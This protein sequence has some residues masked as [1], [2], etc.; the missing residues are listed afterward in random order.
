MAAAAMLASGLAAQV[1]EDLADAD[2]ADAP[3]TPA[4]QAVWR[5]SLVDQEEHA[6]TAAVETGP[7]GEQVVAVG[8]AGDGDRGRLAVRML[9]ATTGE[10]V[11]SVELPRHGEGFAAALD[12]AIGPTGERVVVAGNALDARGQLVPVAM[13]LATDDGSML[14]SAELDPGARATVVDLAVSERGTSAYV[15]TWTY[16]ADRPSE[17]ASLDLATGQVAWREPVSE[18]GELRPVSLAADPSADQVYLLGWEHGQEAGLATVALDGASGAVRWTAREP[19]PVGHGFGLPSDRV[20]VSPATGQVVVA[21]SIGPAEGPRHALLATYDAETGEQ[22]W[23]VRL[24]DGPGTVADPVALTLDASRGRV[25][26]SLAERVPDAD[27]PQTRTLAIDLDTGAVAW[28][29]RTPLAA[30]PTDIELGPDDER[31]YVPGWRGERSPQAVTLAYEAD[32]GA[33]AWTHTGPADARATDVA[34]PDA[35][36]SLVLAHAGST[37][38][39]GLVGLSTDLDTAKAGPSQLAD[40]LA[41]DATAEEAP[42]WDAWWTAKPLAGGTDHPSGPGE[43][44]WVDAENLTAETVHATLLPDGDVLF[45]TEPGP[46]LV[47]DPDTETVD[48]PA[49]P[50]TWLFCSGMALLPDGQLYAP[51]GTTE[52]FPFAGAQTA[53]IF[54]PRS[55]RWVEVA[56]MEH[57]RWYPTAVTLGTGQAGVLTGLTWN[58]SAG[59]H[60]IEEAIVYDPVQDVYRDAGQRKMPT[61]SK[62]YALP[63]GDVVITSPAQAT[64]DWDP[65]EGTF[66]EVAEREGGVRVGAGSALVDAVEG[67]VLEFGGAPGPLA[68]GNEPTAS[69]EIY[70]PETRAWE[71]VEPMHHERVWTDAVL[72]PT[73]DVLAVGGLPRIHD[74]DGDHD[75]DHTASLPVETF[76]PETRTWT[77]GPA[78]GTP[79]AYHSTTLL[80]PDGR[81]L[82]ANQHEG[83][84]KFYEPG[85]LD[86]EDRPV[87]LQAPDDLANGVPFNVLVE[88]PA[89]DE[90]VAIRH[91]S[92]THSLNTDQRRVPLATVSLP[93]FPV[94]HVEPP[95][96][97]ASAIPGPYMLFAMDGEVPSTAPTATIQPGPA[98]ALEPPEDELEP[99]A[100]SEPPGAGLQETIEANQAEHLRHRHAHGSGG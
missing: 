96:N 84:L 22:D 33:L 13:A 49:D 46:G 87:V 59:T 36:A 51:G 72:L 56:S 99:P 94:H 27:D 100:P 58:A 38:S 73:G 16:A 30:H 40:R 17:V 43:G 25:L 93:G 45:Y 41:A 2:E 11:W 85:Y 42:R 90:L 50:N 35:A 8:H 14:W 18:D 21:G 6:S 29:S 26:A 54:D 31:V 63:D 5:S 10:P 64:L 81:V 77:E 61:Y 83:N 52:I 60:I 98:G 23:R 86:S 97:P 65:E 74:H 48:R 28:Q 71:T 80:L 24:A 67:T 76:D 82:A 7:L 12:A 53:E 20:A 1:G 91:S 75:G 34:V 15:A 89:V 69:A 66:Q 19:G 39:P 44:R 37:G 78:P 32:E 47:W 68:W 70:D 92:V 9:D 95:A 79:Y 4:I 62:A 55:E 88:G 57:E 3:G